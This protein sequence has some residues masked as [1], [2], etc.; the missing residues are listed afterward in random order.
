MAGP[1]TWFPGPPL[2]WSLSGAAT[3]AVPGLGNVLIGGDFSSYPERLAAGNA[4][5]TPLPAISSVRIA[6]GAVANG[7]LILVYGGTDGKG[8]TSTLLGYSPSGDTPQPFPAMSVQRSYLGYAPDHNGNAY[9]IGGLDGTGQALSSAERFNPDTGTWSSIASLPTARYDFPAVFDG[10]DSIYV[11]GG[12]ASTTSG[13]E[14]ASVLRYSVRRNTWTNVASLPVPVTGS[15][16]AFGPDGKIYV[17]GGVSGG[18]TTNV[19]QVY[20]PAAKT[21]AIAP[22]LPEGLSAAAMGVDSL[23]RLI[24]MGGLDATGNDVNHVWRSQLLGAPDSPPV[25]TAYPGTNAS[26]LAPYS[27]SIT[28][29]GNPQP[30]YLLIQ[31]PTNMMVD[32]LTGAIAWTPQGLDQIGA[33]PVTIQAT[34]YAGFTDWSFTITVPNPPPTLPANFHVVEATEYSVTLAWDPES[35]VVG[36]VTYGVYI[37][38]PWHDPKGAGAA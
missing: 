14:S 16:A 10:A 5:W 19:V 17:V 23:S 36:P 20:D 6:A 35:P 11:F 9:A 8:S 30:V 28:A 15:A 1:L 7:D 37:P 4:Y 25:L 24:L 34:N 13:T 2:D 33:I 21:W 18:V 32:Y 29:T 12:Y 3:T 26:Y 38:H 31:G 27:S 22:P